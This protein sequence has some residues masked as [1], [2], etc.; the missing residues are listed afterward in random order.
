MTTTDKLTIQ[1]IADALTCLGH[2]PVIYEVPP[3]WHVD[4][5]VRCDN[6][7]HEN[8]TLWTVHSVQQHLDGGGVLPPCTPLE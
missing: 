1:Q 7:C 8:D 2:K 5:G 3:Q 6:C 4:V